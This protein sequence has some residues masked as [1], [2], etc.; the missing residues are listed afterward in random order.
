MSSVVNG[1]ATA[2]AEAHELRCDVCVTSHYVT[3]G[4]SRRCI[5]ERM[6][7]QKKC[8]ISLAFDIHTLGS[9][10]GTPEESVQ[11][12]T[13]QFQFFGSDFTEPAVLSFQVLCTPIFSK[14]QSKRVLHK[15]SKREGRRRG[16]ST[17][18]IHV[19]NSIYAHTR[20]MVATICVQDVV[21]EV[22]CSG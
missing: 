11:G 1:I 20:Y 13:Q 5:F 22:G 16:C 4:M 12:R 2:N 10:P 18:V 9:S 8:S 3:V 6:R 17:L 7:T 21:H 15:E 14:N 19:V